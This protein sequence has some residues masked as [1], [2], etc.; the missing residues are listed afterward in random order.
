MVA[1]RISL[2]T[3]YR[4]LLAIN[5][6]DGKIDSILLNRKNDYGTKSIPKFNSLLELKEFIDTLYPY[7]NATNCNCL[8]SNEGI[9][10]LISF[11]FKNKEEF[12]YV[13]NMQTK[14][15]TSKPKKITEI[16]FKGLDNI[17]SIN[18]ELNKLYGDYVCFPYMEY[19]YTE[20]NYIEMITN[21]RYDDL[22]ELYKKIK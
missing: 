19:G 12:I 4:S 14:F 3:I 2:I 11:S 16:N 7:K 17:N 10:N 9:Y 6:S 20:C 13:N 1:D 8:T 21:E 18:A 22:I 5:S 15:E